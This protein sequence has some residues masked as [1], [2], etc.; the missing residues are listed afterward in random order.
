MTSSPVVG[1]WSSCMLTL[2]PQTRHPEL[3]S[4]P[5][6]P[7]SRSARSRTA[8]RQGRSRTDGSVQT[9]KWVLKQVQDDEE[10]ER[11]S[12][13]IPRGFLGT[14]LAHRSVLGRPG[15]PGGFLAGD[16]LGRRG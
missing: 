9:A 5:I 13:R 14:R 16:L 8:L 1:A 10:G 7:H 15:C 12:F 2:H 6:A 11:R 4:G 3:V